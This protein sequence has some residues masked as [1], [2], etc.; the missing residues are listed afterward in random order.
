[1]GL[2]T[3]TALHQLGGLAHELTGIQTMVL[4]HIVAQHDIE[5]GLAVEDG[6]NDTYETLRNELTDLEDEV[7]RGVGHHIELTRNDGHTVDGAGLADEVLR[8]GLHALG[9][10]L[11]DLLLHRVVLLD[12]LGDD[13]L[14]IL[15]IVEEGLHGTKGVLRLVQQFLA[16]LTGLGL[17][18]TDTGCD[19]TLRDNLE[20]A[21]LT[22]GL[23]V[24][25]TTELTRGTET[26]HAHLVAVLLAEEGD[27]TELLGLFERHITMLVE[28]D[29]LANH[30]VHQT[31]D[32]TDLLV[33]D[34]LEVAE[35]EAQG[36]R[37]YERTLLLDMVA[38]HLL[39]GI[40]EQVGS[41]VV[42]C[43]GIALVGIDTGHELGC[44][45]LRQRLHD[46]NGLVVLTLGVDDVDG[47]GLVADDA[48][49][50]HLTS[51]LTIER[52]IVEHELVELILLLNDLAIAQ[53]MT[54][55][56]RI[57]V[58]DELLLPRTTSLT[59]TTR[60][61]INLYPV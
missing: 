9:L 8:E 1:M 13:A 6:T 26:D 56:L 38:E 11:L 24:N 25:T 4:H 46:M 3:T 33:V 5:Q 49:V 57:V 31:L 54:L 29:I 16:L 35:V 61:T 44:G 15:R 18:T 53:D 55:V 14:Q 45:I 19:R 36:I 22:R 41:R 27:G 60:T 10:E 48:L 34:F 20:E 2:T 50:T 47:L 28:G 21:D 30:T 17:D 23:G 43:R 59:S 32:L 12:I 40:V 52:G 37:R 42:G 7:L 51:H 39:Q 58:A